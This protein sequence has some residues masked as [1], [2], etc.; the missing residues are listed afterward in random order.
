[1][2]PP[3]LIG[4]GLGAITSA[5]MGKS[6]FT[7]A[8]LGGAT[9]G[10]FGGAGGFGSGFSQGGGLL[11]SVGSTATGAGVNLGSVANVADDVALN[12]VD[13][14]ALNQAFNTALPTNLAGGVGSQGINNLSQF[15]KPLAGV[16][17]DI[18]ASLADDISIA[19]R[20]MPSTGIPLSLGETNP[21]ALDPRRMVVNTPLTFGERLSDIGSSAFSYGKENP[22][23]LLGG[24]NT[25]SGLSNQ[26]DQTK[27]QRLNEAV[28]T[29]T[30][31][32]QRKQFDP[33]SVIAAAPSYGLSREE[34]ARGKIGQ[35]ASQARLN[36]EDERRIGQFY[37]SLIG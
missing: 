25:L 35:I 26:E 12:A 37:Q 15:A 1:M 11:S 2:G 13:D 4:A 18:G 24:A 32:I 3:V 7:G 21:F 31:P 22:M 30:Q 29:G 28:A 6:P 34:V 19:S 23:T 27:Q 36:D 33:S 5:A 8:L 16:T 17:D 9:G 10:M 20:G 14:V